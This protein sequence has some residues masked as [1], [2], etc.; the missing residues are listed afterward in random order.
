ML[1]LQGN[2]PDFFYLCATI[3]AFSPHSS[4]TGAADDGNF[5]PAYAVISFSLFIF[6][7]IVIII[8]DRVQH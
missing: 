3:M 4:L 5:N 8:S 2:I 1:Y 6:C 7:V